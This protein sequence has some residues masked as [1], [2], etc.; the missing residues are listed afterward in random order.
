MKHQLDANP[1]V[2]PAGLHAQDIGTTIRAGL[3][4]M[5]RE[6]IARTAC[7]IS[8]DPILI[9]ID[10]L[11]LPDWVV[12]WIRQFASF[13]VE[14]TQTCQEPIYSIPV[15][16]CHWL[17]AHSRTLPVREDGPREKPESGRRRPVGLCPASRWYGVRCRRDA[18]T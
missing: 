17:D 6:V 12:I 15:L 10:E 14:N 3:V 11:T 2:L 5:V 16:R 7:D 13:V 9:D 18:R 1:A 8:N 4:R